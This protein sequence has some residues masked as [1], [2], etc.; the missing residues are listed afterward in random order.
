MS[1]VIV[2]NK[3]FT[4]Q[5]DQVFLAAS[6]QIPRF[7]VPPQM[8]SEGD[9]QQIQTMGGAA[10]NSMLLTLVIPFL[11]MIF[12]SASMSRVWSFYNML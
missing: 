11:F 6:F 4:A 5:L 9:Y 10:Q 3:L 8:A 12:M 1:I 7:E 2:A